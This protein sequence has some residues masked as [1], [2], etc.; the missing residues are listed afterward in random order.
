MK[1]ILFPSMLLIFL[2]FP[3]CRNS[4]KIHPVEFVDR[5][6]IYPARDQS[7]RAPDPLLLV[8]EIS[9]DGKLSLNKIEAGTIADLSPLAEKLKSVFDER[10]KASISRRAVVIDS[11]NKI[12]SEEDLAKLVEALAKLK[13]SPIRII[14]Q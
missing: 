3:G 1:R 14:Q 9:A 2:S 11:K 13:A 7:D 12:G 4:A 8:V 5:S 10:A 6:E